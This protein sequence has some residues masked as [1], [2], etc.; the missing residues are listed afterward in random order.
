MTYRE[1]QLACR[2]RGLPAI[3]K[4][5]VLRKNL[6]DFIRDP[7]GTRERIAREAPATK[8]KARDG[9]VNWR[10]HAA[11]EILWED[12]EPGGWLHGLDNEDARAVFDVYQSRQAEFQDIPFAQFE[13]RYNETIKRATKRRARALQEEH[14]FQHDRLL[15]PRQSHNHRG[16]PVF[17]M[18]ATA[19][20]QL[21]W[22]VDNK[23]HKQYTPMKLWE[24]RPA[25]YG[26]YKLNIFRAKIYQV[27]RK[28]KFINWL[29]KKRT[30][31]RKEF[32]KKQSG[33][34][35]R[36]ERS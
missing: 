16:E 17:D 34:N 24:L 15:H 22:D 13:A 5:E 28:K 32:A 36:F 11:R 8:K 4:T 25:I 29:E 20:A 26:K 14:F 23:L 33:G 35:V 6:E 12:I 1:L 31:K 3:G 7:E 19:K 18:D 10:M 2:E 9:W 30:E 27:V 21:L